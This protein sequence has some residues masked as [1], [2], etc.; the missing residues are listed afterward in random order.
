MPH[1][2]IRQA[3]APSAPAPVRGLGFREGLD[4]AFWFLVA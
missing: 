3:A 4:Q 2:A 1:R